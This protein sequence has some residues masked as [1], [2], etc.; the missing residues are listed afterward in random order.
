[1]KRRAAALLFFCL[2]APAMG[3][4][5][6]D[7]TLNDP[8]GDDYGPGDYVYPYDSAFTPGSFDV[9]RFRAFDQG[10]NIKFEVEIDGDLADPWGSG[11]GFSLQSIDI[12]IDT[13][14]VW[15]SG[16]TWALERRNVT[17]S[18][19]SAWEYVVWCQAPFDGF[20]TFVIDQYGSPY[21]SGISVVADQVDDV[22]TITV[23]KAT[24]GTPSSAWRYAVLMLGQNGYEPGR[25]RPVRRNA[26]SW[27]FGGG[28]D[29]QSDAN[30]I[31][32]VAGSGVPQEALLANYNQLTLVSPILINAVDA[33]APVIAYS[34]PATWEAHQM[35][36]VDP[37]IEDDVVVSASLFW[38]K[39]GDAYTEVEMWRTSDVHWVAFI[40]GSEITGTAVEY[41]ISATD[42]TNSADLPGAGSP[43][44]V[45]IT[46]DTTPPALA[47]FDASPDPFSPNGDGFRDSTVVTAALSEPSYLWISITDSLGAHV[48][49]LL[50]SVYTEG[51][52]D[53]GWDGR[54]DMSL[55][56]PEG[57]YTL[58][59][60]ARD[61]AGLPSP[62][63]STFPCQPEPG[64]LRARGQHLVL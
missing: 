50:D 43:F 60:R 58:H 18:P 29:G 21:Y 32:M 14:G 38:R 51:A 37:D 7:V 39:P 28:E 11:A 45:T 27:A 54:D 41:Y 42:G 47:Y 36:T 34:A 9:T 20:D 4:L 46:P 15:G 64:A 61:L 63:G 6:Y 1:L 23:P 2:W 57:T 3:A 16:A 13:D 55:P 8:A 62:A 24:L 10:S 17:F 44:V 5:A 40:P 35:L 52:R 56:L 30:V 59:V 12:Y 49:T 53:T 31:D 26:D 48:R 22:I 33:A 25:V 19:S